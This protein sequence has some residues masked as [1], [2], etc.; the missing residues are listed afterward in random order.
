MITSMPMHTELDLFTDYDA[1]E[2]EK[3]EKAKADIRERNMQA[4][5]VNIKKKFG[6]NAILKGLNFREGS[7]ARSRNRQIGGHKA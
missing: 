4:A 6:K 1:L 2:A 7:T 5:L 3:A